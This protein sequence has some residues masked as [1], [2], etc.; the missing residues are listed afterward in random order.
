METSNQTESQD[1]ELPSELIKSPGF[2]GG[3]QVIPNNNGSYVDDTGRRVSVRRWD[4]NTL[5]KVDDIEWA[6][7]NTALFFL[8]GCRMMVD[9]DTSRPP[10]IIWR[11]SLDLM[12]ALSENKMKDLLLPEILRTKAQADTKMTIVQP[13]NSYLYPALSEKPLA[14]RLVVLLPSKHRHKISDLFCDLS[15]ILCRL[16]NATLGGSKYEALSYVW[17]DISRKKPITIND[18]QFEATENLERALRHLRSRDN[19]RVL[20]IDS[21]CINQNEIDE[22]NA[23]VRQM[24]LIYSSSQRVIVWLGPES[25][26]SSLAIKFQDEISQDNHGRKDVHWG[27]REWDIATSLLIAVNHLMRRAWFTRIW[28]VQEFILGRHVVFHCGQK[29]LASE[30]FERFIINMSELSTQDPESLALEGR[31]EMVIDEFRQS[32]VEIGRFFSWKARHQS[33]H[34]SVLNLLSDFSKWVS[35]DPRDKVFGLYGIVPKDNPDREVLKPDYHLNISEVYT[36]VAVYFLQKYR[37]LDIL[38]IATQP[39]KLFINTTRYHYLPSW[40]PDWRDG[41]RFS[42]E[43]LCKPIAFYRSDRDAS[44]FDNIYNASLH[45]EATPIDILDH[46]QVLVLKGID[47]DIIEVIGTIYTGFH[48]GRRETRQKDLSEWKEIAGVS[49]DCRYKFS[50]QPVYEA[51]WRTILGDAQTD[52]NRG[53]F[54]SR[55]R[56]ALADVELDWLPSFPPPSQ[57][58]SEALEDATRM[59]A[60]MCGRRFFK[61]SMGLF[62]LAPV[63]AEKGDHVVVLFGGRCPFILRKF[64]SYVHGIMDG[65]IISQPR[66]QEFQN[67]EVRQFHIA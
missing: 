64:E 20:W 53:D 34:I 65:E 10:S 30:D 7:H 47:V 45:Y 62:G 35:S 25:D 3:W 66:I 5:S 31:K 24:D 2:E 19:P 9:M 40:V 11:E 51:W 52:D 32:T 12:L 42:V 4:G 36:K 58:D 14:I 49:N 67:L 60:L 6:A 56:L 21:I 8:T 37:N 59:K 23:Q 29:T 61:T 39:V 41:Q 16:C 38:S 55:C 63:W 48:E 15:D 22:R 27:M 17:G 18:E 28:C 46:G 1:I 43:R 50:D 33:S 13:L 54:G 57:D 44:Y 26:D